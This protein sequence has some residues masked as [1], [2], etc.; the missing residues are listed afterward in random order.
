MIHNAVFIEYNITK[1]FADELRVIGKLTHTVRV[2]NKG[3]LDEYKFP[4]GYSYF[5][6][7]ENKLVLCKITE[8]QN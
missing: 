5:I 1:E 4:S 2:E 8:L 7:A 3:K 6:T